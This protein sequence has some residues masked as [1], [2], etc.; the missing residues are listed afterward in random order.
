M[1]APVQMYAIK[2]KKLDPDVEAHCIFEL[3]RAVLRQALLD[4][5]DDEQAVKDNAREWLL[6]HGTRWAEM[7][8]LDWI[9]DEAIEHYLQFGKKRRHK[10]SRPS[11]QPN[12]LESLMP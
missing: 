11:Q 5:Q 3:A 12:L 10:Q 8:D 1:M 6:T 7:L 9:D 2:R 4:A